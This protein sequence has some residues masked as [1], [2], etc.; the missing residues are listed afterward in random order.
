[1]Q[2]STLVVSSVVASQPRVIRYVVNNIQQSHDAEF[3]VSVPGLTVK[4]VGQHR[5][6][7]MRTVVTVMARCFAPHRFHVRMIDPFR[8]TTVRRDL[9]SFRPSQRVDLPQPLAHQIIAESPHRTQSG[10]YRRLGMKAGA[11]PDVLSEYPRINLFDPDP[12]ALAL[13]PPP[14]LVQSCFRVRYRLRANSPR[15][16]LLHVGIHQPVPSPHRCP[17]KHHKFKQ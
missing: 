17:P 9:G 14:P 15:P 12:G 2:H 5:D 16:I 4:A 7:Q 1:M 10:R 6:P 8:Q 3:A 11:L 13:K